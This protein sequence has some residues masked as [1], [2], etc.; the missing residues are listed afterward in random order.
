[1]SSTTSEERSYARA[2][3]RVRALKGLYIHSL[4]F[5]LVNLGLFGINVLVGRPWWFLWSVLGWG[6]G[7]G[8]HAIVV[9]TFSDEW[10]ERKIEQ[11]VHKERVS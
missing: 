7:L 4:V 1:M 6:V 3:A 10:E 11:I 9:L 2:R 5:M 8:A